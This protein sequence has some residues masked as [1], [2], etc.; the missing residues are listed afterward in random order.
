MSEQR[1]VVAYNVTFL[2]WVLI[3]HWH[4]PKKCPTEFETSH[5][6]INGVMKPLKDFK[7]QIMCPV[8][9]INSSSV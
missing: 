5:S 2:T 6:Y 7:G 9:G 3:E 1:T 8:Q 4:S